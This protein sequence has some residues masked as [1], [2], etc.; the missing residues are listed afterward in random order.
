MRNELNPYK[1]M[2]ES[3]DESNIIN[4]RGGL[5][6]L[7]VRDNSNK[8][9]LPLQNPLVISIHLFYNIIRVYIQMW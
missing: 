8:N 6:L 5:P 7:V 1:G 4:V 3:F 9:G 2:E